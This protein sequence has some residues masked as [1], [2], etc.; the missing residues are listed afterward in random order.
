MPLLHE[1]TQGY[2]SALAGYCRTGN[3]HPIPGVRDAHVGHY[4]R[5]VYNVI[6]DML[7]SA[8]PLT[9]D[10]LTAA[11]WEAL[12]QEFFSSHACQSPQVWYMP[13]ELYQYTTTTEHALLT[14][15]PF[16]TELLWLEWLEVEL[17]MMEDKPA[18]FSLSGDVLTDPLV[19]NPE[20]A[21]QHF[22]YP[23]HLMP[24]RQITAKEKGDYFLVM[25]RKPDTGNVEYMDLSPALVYIL[26]QLAVKPCR[27]EELITDVCAALQIPVQESISAMVCS[28]LQRSLES[29][30]I[31]GFRNAL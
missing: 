29:R 3:Y 20:Y 12:V 18:T 13:K 7:Q 1:T 24:A 31:L 5:L 14:K 16:L 6:N 8:Y 28:F 22:H 11:E 21:L 23:V 4:R 27:A 9:Y 25:F 2:Q 26:E 17:F 10:V 30:L 15:Y 19:L